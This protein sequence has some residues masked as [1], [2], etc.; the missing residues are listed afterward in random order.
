LRR[1][2][3]YYV[4]FVLC[5]VVPNLLRL[6]PWIWDNI[7]ILIYW[8]VGSIP[9]AAL[10]LTRLARL[11][12][13]GRLGAVAAFVACTAAGALDLWRVSSAAFESRVYDRAGMQFAEAVANVSARDALILHAPIHN[14]PVALSGRRSLM[15]YPGHVW[16]HG[17]DSGSREADIRRM[18]AGAADAS[19]LLTRYGID[20]VVVGPYERTFGVNET[21]FT[22]WTPIVEVEQYRLYRV[23]AGGHP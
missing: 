3:R 22:R 17:L 4:P 16:S 7:K 21:F 2:R 1:L 11:G 23:P 19:R 13:V 14:H 10:A 9:L 12:R 15:G 5:F 18:Y 20:F 6:A 8:F